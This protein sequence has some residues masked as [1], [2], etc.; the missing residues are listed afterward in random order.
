MDDNEY[1]PKIDI[2]DLIKYAVGA[3][4]AVTVILKIK[5]ASAEVGFFS[6]SNHGVSNL[7]IDQIYRM[8]Q[9]FFYSPLDQKTMLSP[10]K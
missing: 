9:S 2:V 5:K 7:S 8:A 1:I 3:P 10:K 6:V 4:E